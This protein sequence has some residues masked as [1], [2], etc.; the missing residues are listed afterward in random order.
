VYDYNQT[1][2]KNY[3]NNTA[4]LQGSLGA[5]SSNNQSWKITVPRAQGNAAFTTAPIVVDAIREAAWDAAVAYPVANKFAAN[6]TVVA[7]DA[8]AQ[9][10]VRILWDGPVLYVLVEVTGDATQ[11]DT[12]IPTWNTASYSPAT[13]GLFVS[14]DVFNDK[15]GM[16][17][18]TAGVF[19]LPANPA[20]PTTSFNNGGIPSLGSFFHPLN[21]DYS[22]RLKAYKSSGYVAGAG[23]N[24]TYEFA[25]QIEGWG[26][27]WERELANGTQIGLEVGIFNQGAS[28]TYWSKTNPHAGK[29]GNSNLPNSERPRNRDWAEVTLAGWDGA[30]PFAYSGWR[31]DENIR[32]WNSKSNPGGTGLPNSGD[33]SVVW[34]PESKSLMVGAKN[35]YLNLK[36]NGT[37]TR[38]QLEAAVLQVC[39]AFWVLSWADKKFPDPHDLPAVK[40][41]PNVWKFF[42]PSK[43]TNGMVTNLAEWNQRKH[44]LRELAQFYEY[45]YKPKLGVDYTISL[46]AN[47]YSGTGNPQVIATVTPTNVNFNGGVAS[48]LT[49]NLTL[50][51]AGLP[52]GQKAVIGFSTNMT[53]NGLANIGLPT[54]W[55]ADSRSDNGAWGNPVSNPPGNRTGVFYTFF[56]YTRNSTSADVSFSMAVATGVSIYL[57]I[58]QMAVAA[59]P[60]LAARIDPTRAVTKGFSINGKHAFVAA[61]FDERVKATIP[62]GAGATGPANWRY[63]CTGQEYDFTGTPFYNPGAEAIVSHGTEGPGNSYRHNRVRETELFRHFMS[64]G[65]MYSH[66]EGSYGY[67]NYSRLPFDNALLVATLAPDRAI[68]IDTNLNDYNDGAVTDNMSLQVAKFVY[69]ALGADADKYV[70]FNSG[71]YVSVGDPHG[72][73]SAV[74]EG[75]Y[76]SDF[77]YGT[78]TVTEVEATRLNTDPYNLKVSNG[79]TQT[80]YD[81]YWGGFNTITGGT[82]GPAGLDGWRYYNLNPP[83]VTR[84]GFVLNRRTNQVTQQVTLKNVSS[85]TVTGPLYLVLDSLSSNTTLVNA[86]GTTSGGR[87]YIQSAGNLAPGASRV[88]VLTFT[89][90]ASGGI[91]YTALTPASL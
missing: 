35:A 61:V 10:T 24:Y 23:I 91:T 83:T 63:N 81:Y 2:D 55:G 26:D 30:T 1:G 80:P 20:A 69:K 36:D 60:A 74:P 44:E 73:A 70:K 56:P 47:A 22:T 18:D 39:Q 12:G 45:G 64:Y 89:N 51:I 79:Q 58:L 5:T 68:M 77:F 13:D 59:N 46:V 49:L 43:G 3:I 9:G 14:M 71:N 8:T 57:D 66:E 86:T 87:P 54:N 16:E 76:M 27:E 65:H 41:L 19:F 78:Q 15:W 84:G 31:A 52:E 72:A 50:P 11:S 29:E 4:V 40:T 7:P 75:H 90:P 82:G 38:E 37:A 34:T 53:A 62:G 21:L 6:M 88:L 42:D 85:Q 17:N 25:L 32:F 28:F 48:N 67:G 33:N